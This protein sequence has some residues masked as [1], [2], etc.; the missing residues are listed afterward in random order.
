M[1]KFSGLTDANRAGAQVVLEHD[2]LDRALA[3]HALATIDKSV[4]WL[5]VEENRVRIAGRWMAVPRGQSAYGDHGTSYRFSGTEVFARPWSEC[6]ILNELRRAIERKLGAS[7]NFVFVNRYDGGKQHISWHRDDE[8]DLEPGSDIVSYTLGA[9]RDFAFRH[10]ETRERFQGPLHHNTLLVMKPPTNEVCE[11]CVPKRS[12][13]TTQG[14][15]FNLTFRR[16][17]RRNRRRPV[18]PEDVEPAE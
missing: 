11:H 13:S 1:S 5:G 6:P 12:E 4:K 2:F 8:V 10:L 16:M 15:R 14:V 3:D 7:F 18:E 17:V 9:S